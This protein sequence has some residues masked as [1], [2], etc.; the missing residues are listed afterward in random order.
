VASWGAAQSDATIPIDASFATLPT[1]YYRQTIRNVITP[2]LG[3]SRVRVHLTNRYD[4]VPVTFGAVTIGTSRPGGGVDPP[5]PVLFA[6][7]TTVT[8]PPGQDAVSDPLDLTVEPFTPLTVSLYVPNT[9]WQLTKHWNSNATTFLTTAG[10]GDLTAASSG[11]A[12]TGQV[13]SWLGVLA[14]DVEAGPGTRAVVAFG[15]SI[16]DGWVAKSALS[17]LDTSVSN[18]NSRYPDFLQHRIADR[19]LP[20]SVI[21]A[22][23]GS[24]QI[25]GSIFPIAGP[26]ALERF[27][28]D[29]PYFASAA[30]VIILEGINDLGLS[31]APGGSIIDGL[32]QLVARA[33]AAHLKVWLATITPAS[34]AVVDGV[35]LAPNS[36]RDRQFVNEWIRSQTI[37]DG[38]FDFDAAVRDPSDPAVLAPQYSSLDHLHLSPA[39]YQRL[40]DSVDLDQLGTLLTPPGTPGDTCR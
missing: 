26:S 13:Q 37:A 32:T 12:F 8:I 10:S 4:P 20:L 25:L 1:S 31:Q 19:G 2:H 14:L 11:A 23:L 27:T 36:E 24:N 3:G 30:G 38:Y 33:H 7:A 28:A 16:T 9:P 29:V 15:D 5:T 40:A 6:G 18:T 21:N 34:N 39:G 22:G 35:L 17:E